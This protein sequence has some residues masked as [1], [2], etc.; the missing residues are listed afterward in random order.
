MVANFLHPCIH[1]CFSCLKRTELIKPYIKAKQINKISTTNTRI[2]CLILHNFVGIFK[3]NN[4]RAN[5]KALIVLKASKLFVAYEKYFVYKDSNMSCILIQI[6][7]NK[8]I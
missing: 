4:Y 5:L 8:G 1:P 7:Y 2:N 3:Q 6:I